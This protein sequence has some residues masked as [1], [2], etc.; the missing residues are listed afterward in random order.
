VLDKHYIPLFIKHVF[1]KFFK[2]HL[3][4]TDYVVLSNF[5]NASESESVFS[6]FDKW[7]YSSFFLH[8]SVQYET[9]LHSH[10]NY[11]TFIL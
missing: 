8:S 3:P 11:N 10:G 2:P 6:H 9:F 1:P 5:Y 4:S 7:Y